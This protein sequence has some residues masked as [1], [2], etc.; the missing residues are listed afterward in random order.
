[1]R[2]LSITQLLIFYL[3][4]SSCRFEY[5]PYN[6]GKK[7][8]ESEIKF[9]GGKIGSSFISNSNC[10]CE[11]TRKDLRMQASI[12]NTLLVNFPCPNVNSRTGREE[13]DTMVIFRK[14]HLCHINANGDKHKVKLNFELHKPLFI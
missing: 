13:T 8:F 10:L 4:I 7:V 5:I 3:I 11:E 14:S 1:M 12:N 9:G 2:A 6:I